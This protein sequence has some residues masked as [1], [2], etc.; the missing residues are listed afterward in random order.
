MLKPLLFWAAST[1]APYVTAPAEWERLAHGGVAVS[2]NDPAAQVWEACGAGTLLD[3]LAHRTAVRLPLEGGG[4]RSFGRVLVTADEVARSYAGLAASG[5][6]AAS[7]VRT[8]MLEVP[9]RQTFGVRPLIARRLG[10]AGSRI[11]VKSGWFCDTDEQ[12]IRTHVVTM[13]PTAGGVVGTVVLTAFPADEAIRRAYTALYRH[14]DEVLG[15]H[16]QHAGAAVRA[17]TEHAASAA[18]SL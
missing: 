14:G 15:L 12:R 7:L 9:D 18:L 2:A 10:V 3:A 5:D 13:T 4:A 17:A 8:W 16:E 11:A 6:G 1:L